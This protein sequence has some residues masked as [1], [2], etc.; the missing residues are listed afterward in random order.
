L[1]L[2]C[3]K[4]TLDLRGVPDFIALTSQTINRVS[5]IVGEV[6]EWRILENRTVFERNALRRAADGVIWAPGFA[7]GWWKKGVAWLLELCPAPALIAC[8]PDPAGIEIALDVARI[9]TEK[10][11]AWQP[12]HM[13]AETLSGLNRKKGLTENDKDRLKRL[14]LLSMPQTLRELST[15]MLENGEKGEQE[16]IAF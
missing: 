8:D 2:I 11:L 14:L 10:G 15:W 3:S 9:W 4:G 1:A 6:R 12:W 7:P 16:G 13:D 5:R